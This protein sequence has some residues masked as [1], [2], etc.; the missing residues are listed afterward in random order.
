[1]VD[2]HPLSHKITFLDSS[3][4]SES[5]NMSVESYYGVDTSKLVPTTT[6]K[7][8]WK[9]RSTTDGSL[10]LFFE[11]NLPTPPRKRDPSDIITFF[12]P[13][14]ERIKIRIPSINLSSSDDWIK[15]S[16]LVYGDR[17]SFGSAKGHDCE[18]DHMYSERRKR[19]VHKYLIKGTSVLG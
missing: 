15:E 12:A 16:D 6:E 11:D 18:K 3:E 13:P 10:A 2:G 19:C 5:E 9:R 1:M 8:L 7:P 4:E 17:F 14:I